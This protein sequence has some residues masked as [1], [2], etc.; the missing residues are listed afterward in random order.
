MKVLRMN[1]NLIGSILRKCPSLGGKCHG[2]N[3]FQDRDNTLYMIDISLFN[4]FIN[5]RRRKYDSYIKRSW[6]CSVVQ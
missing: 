2:V 3:E 4:D 5:H 6:E 1:C